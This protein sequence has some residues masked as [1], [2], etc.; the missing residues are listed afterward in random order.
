MQG[1]GSLKLSVKMYNPSYPTFYIVN[2]G[3]TGVCFFFLIFGLSDILT[4]LLR[5][6][7]TFT[8]LLQATEIFEKFGGGG[9]GHHCPLSGEFWV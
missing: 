3:C 1:C 5:F 6:W 4:V 8:S 2:L 7:V 9:C